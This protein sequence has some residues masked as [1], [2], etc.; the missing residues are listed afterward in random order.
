MLR[1]TY[2]DRLKRQQT[3]RETHDTCNHQAY[4]HR[5]KDTYRVAQKIDTIL[6][7]ALISSNINGFS[8]I[9]Y[10]QN[11]KKICNN[12]ITK[13]PITPQLCHYTTL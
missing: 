11:Q 8:K 13:G 6:L 4:K 9:F 7:Y 1:R 3:A 12:T 10:C 5:Y 2:S